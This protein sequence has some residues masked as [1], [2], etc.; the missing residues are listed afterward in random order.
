[1]LQAGRLRV[2][3]LMRSLNFFNLPNPSSCTMALG[4]TQPLTETSTR[5]YSGGKVR[6][7]CQ[8]DNLTELM[9]V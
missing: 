8:A 4:F 7:A 6:P 5:R 1:M 2:R 9:T 3:V